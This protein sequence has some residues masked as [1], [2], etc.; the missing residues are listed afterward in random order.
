M[1]VRVCVCE[2]SHKTHWCRVHFLYKRATQSVMCFP[3]GV[4]NSLDSRLIRIF[5]TRHEPPSY[6]PFNT[7]Q[8]TLTGLASYVRHAYRKLLNVYGV[9][10]FD[11]QREQHSSKRS[12]SIARHRASQRARQL[13]AVAQRQVQL[14][15][16]E[17]CSNHAA[18]LV[19]RLAIHQKQL[20]DFELHDQLHLCTPGHAARRRLSSQHQQ[21]PH[22][23]CSSMSTA[24]APSHLQLGSRSSK[25]APPKLYLAASSLAQT[26]QSGKG[27]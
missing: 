16:E 21:Q 19:D 22:R 1:C 26:P 14:E 12:S 2:C 27:A 3:R 7:Q 18:E 5:T 9:P 17:T 6:L 13:L 8:R 15:V 10:S 24:G 23:R 20:P 11:I 4:P 25:T